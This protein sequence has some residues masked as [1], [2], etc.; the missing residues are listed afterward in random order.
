M[1][2]NL[3]IPED[4][5][6]QSIIMRP[7]RVFRCMGETHNGPYMMVRNDVDK[8]GGKYYCKC[9]ELVKDVTNTQT[10]HDFLEI[11]NV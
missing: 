2:L 3:D 8:R 11:V 4:R 7:K 5:N 10:G 9:G 1:N 6:L